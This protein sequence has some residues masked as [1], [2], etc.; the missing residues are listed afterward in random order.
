MTPLNYTRLS[1]GLSRLLLDA[2]KTLPYRTR[3]H[4][5]LEIQH[6]VK[7]ARDLINVGR[8]SPGQIKHKVRRAIDDVLKAVKP[9]SSPPAPIKRITKKSVVRDAGVKKRSSKRREH[10]CAEIACA[11]ALSELAAKPVIFAEA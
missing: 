7:E 5:R 11:K 4:D 8:Y 3:T 2:T 6:I 9:P 10:T 1:A